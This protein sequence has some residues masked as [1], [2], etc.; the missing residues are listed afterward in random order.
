MPAVPQAGQVQA[1]W[2]GLGSGFL[3]PHSG[4]NLPVMPAVPQAGQVQPSGAGGGVWG[5]CCCCWAIWKRFWALVPAPPAMFIPMKAMAAPAPS[6]AA[7][8]CMAAA[9]APTRWAPAR[10]GSMKAAFRCS[11]LII[12]SSSSE[13]DTLDTPKETISRPRPFRH[14]SLRTSLRAW[15]ISSVCMGRAEYRMPIW[16]I[17]PKAGWRAVRSSVF[18]WPSMV[19]RVK[20]SATLLVT[21]L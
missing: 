19:S 14:F 20:A 13:A 12:F 17:R 15:A 16:E 6:L 9:W 18:S 5:A 8:A 3:P 1:P 7:A 4:Q 11:S 21:F 2:A 10:A